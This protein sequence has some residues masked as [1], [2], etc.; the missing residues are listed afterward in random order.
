MALR[1]PMGVVSR[2]VGYLVAETENTL[3]QSVCQCDAAGACGNPSAS[4]GC[5]N[6]IGLGASLVACGSTRASVDDLSLTASGLPSGSFATPLMGRAS[7]G[8][9]LGNGTLCLGGN[10][11]R[12][13]VEPASTGTVE[14]TGLV[15][16]STASHPAAS[17][18]AAGR[19]WTFQ[20]WYRDIGGPCGG[21]SNTTDALTITF[22][23]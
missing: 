16:T 14:V 11:L 17:A 19:T 6:S 2:S 8:T 20:L 12:F 18:I 7:A 21:T 9:D 22:T 4:G 1:T 10:I 5:I 23:P 3:V 13:P 15:A